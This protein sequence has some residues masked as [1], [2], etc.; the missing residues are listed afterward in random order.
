M[1]WVA[2]Q[3]WTLIS[4]SPGGESEIRGRHGQVLVTDVFWSEVEF[5]GVSSHGERATEHLGPYLRTRTRMA[6]RRPPPPRPI[7]QGVN[8]W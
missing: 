2:F 3:Q 6:S 8:C 4:D 5:F 7:A 1:K